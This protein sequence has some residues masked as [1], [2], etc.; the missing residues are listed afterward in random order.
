MHEV[1]FLSDLPIDVQNDLS[2]RLIRKNYSK[3]EFIFRQGDEGTSLYLIKT[4]EVKISSLSIEGRESILAIL[5]PG[6]TFGEL[7]LFDSKPRSTDAVSRSDCELLSL[8]NENFWQALDSH[9]A[10]YKRV[11]EMMSLR[12][13]Q[14]DQLIEDSA[15]LDVPARL[16]RVLLRIAQNEDHSL[17]GNGLVKVS[18]SELA[19]MVGATREMVNKSLRKLEAVGHVERHGK[20]ILVKS[21]DGLRSLIDH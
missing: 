8:S 18:Q 16:A 2:D 5:W 17:G 10:A 7:A 6:D 15:F 4:G 20:E 14:A 12:L 21:Y 11:L 9:P 19:G 13:R 3:G 1:S